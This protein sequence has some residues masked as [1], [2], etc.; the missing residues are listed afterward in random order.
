M[1]GLEGRRLEGDEFS[2]FSMRIKLWRFRKMSKNC[3]LAE[4]VG[5]DYKRMVCSCVFDKINSK[6]PLL[7]KTFNEIPRFL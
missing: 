3:I 6:I 1:E 4:F 7:S 5:E 2:I